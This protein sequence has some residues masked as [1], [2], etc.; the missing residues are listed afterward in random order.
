M[1]KFFRN[2]KGINLISLTI[3]V[4]VILIITNIVIYNVSFANRYKQ[5]ER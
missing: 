4:V 2:Q 3:T 5:F 1:K